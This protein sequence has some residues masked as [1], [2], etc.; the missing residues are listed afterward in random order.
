MIRK[1]HVGV[2]SVVQH[3]LDEFYVTEMRERHPSEGSGT[4]VLELVRFHAL[5]IARFPSKVKG[6]NRPD[7]GGKPPYSSESVI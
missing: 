6:V 7:V 5:I 4:G 2:F 1:M 3:L